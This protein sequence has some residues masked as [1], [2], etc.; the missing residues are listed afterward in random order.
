MANRIQVSESI[1]II[2]L[3]RKG[4][5]KLRIAR[6]LALDVKTVRRC[7]REAAEGD[8]KFLISPP[9]A[10]E[11]GDSKGT[12][13]PPG[14]SLGKTEISGSGPISKSL[15]SP[16]G[17]SGRPSHCE[18]YRHRIEAGLETGLSAQRI[19]QDLADDGFAGAYDSVKRFV[20]KRFA[21][22]APRVH[23]MECLPGEEAQV[24]FGL[25]AP[26]RLAD[27]RQKRTWVFRIV[28]SCSRK[29][30]SEAVVRQTTENFIRCLE[31]AFRYFGGVPATVVI[32]NLRAAVT[33]AD[34]YEPELNPKIRELARHYG[35]VIL[36][37][38]PRCP[39]HKGKVES[40]VKYVK[41]NALKG[42]LFDSLADE[43]RHL[44]QWESQVADQRIHGTI[45]RQVAQLF[46]T[47]RPHL[48]PLPAMLFPCFQE[49]RRRVHRDSFVEVE[50]AYYEVR[51]Q[52][53]VGRDV[54]VRWDG[55]LVRIFNDKMEQ[56]EVHARSEK[57]KFSYCENSTSRG[58][59]CGMEHT[60]AWL[61]KR[62]IKIGPQCGAWADAVALNRGAEG[63]RPL[64]GL[65]TLPR[66]YEVAAIEEACKVAL[67]HGAYSLRDLRRLLD[68][69]V[70]GHDTPLFMHSHPLIRDMAEYGAFLE[71]LYPAE[72]A[73]APRSAQYK[74]KGAE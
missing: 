3:F 58:R 10:E 74:Q 38:R 4:W 55:R 54:W 29:A 60:T 8:S 69:P 71:T 51:A 44:L 22:L 18:P 39:E 34:W 36:P 25:G 23:R 53:Y 16:A 11:R 65:L 37:T 66:R 5:P 43:N 70:Q 17:K 19:F 67:S 7:I 48:L 41:N 59:L 72:E 63:I 49:G 26:I 30:Y 50:K 42:R 62:A 52:E 45:R 35:T 68:R 27:G 33:R 12:V 9:G 56:I 15:I 20:K 40:S 46:E 61:L 32:D 1:T 13:S 31:N 28:L 64:Y 21:H 2:E 57:G 47:E 24:D 6:E 73:F 14:D